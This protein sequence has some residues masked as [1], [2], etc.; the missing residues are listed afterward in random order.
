MAWTIR[1]FGLG[2]NWLDHPGDCVVAMGYQS[3]LVGSE[4]QW[5][6]WFLLILGFGIAMGCGDCQER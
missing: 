2:L 5:I 4:I 3:A 1:I 6:K